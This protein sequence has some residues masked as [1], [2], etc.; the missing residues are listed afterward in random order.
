MVLPKG[1]AKLQIFSTTGAV[2]WAFF[3]SKGE[4]VADRAWRGAKTFVTLRPVISVFLCKTS[5]T[6]PSLPTSTMARPRSWTRCSL[7]ATSSARTRRPATSCLT[8]TTWNANAASRSSRRTSLLIIK[9]SRS[10]LSTPRG[11]PTSAARSNACS[12]WPTAASCLSM[13]LR[14]RCPRHALCS[15]RRSKSA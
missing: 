8:T 13:P 14:G 5:V 12:T 11:T 2:G 4:G 10:T 1:A 9:V 3:R 6:S 7:P 15:K